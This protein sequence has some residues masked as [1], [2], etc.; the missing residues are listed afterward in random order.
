[1]SRVKKTLRL[2][3]KF[4]AAC[5][6]IAVLGFVEQ[7]GNNVPVR[8][9]RVNLA[10]AGDV[11]F[12]DAEA[13]KLQV[14]TGTGPV[15]G[16]PVNKLDETAIEQHLRAIPCVAEADV[17]HTMDGVLHV[18]ARQREP[19]VRVVNADGTGFYIDKEGWTMPLDPNYTARVMVVTGMLQEPFGMQAPVNVTS[20][21][22]SLA[23]HSH[24]A[25]IH[26]LA[27]TL[28]KNPFWSALFGQ[29]VVDAQGEFTLV[30]NVGMMQVRVGDGSHLAQRLDKLKLFY[31]QGLP[32]A[33]WRRYST[34]D[35]RFDDQV[36][37]T[38]RSPQ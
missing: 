15:I 6:V 22:D 9:V 19:I 24:C 4:A 26:A 34:V 12:I 3:A 8:E 11:H 18:N 36:V 21:N 13:L 30:P 10:P 16:T 29:A 7:R 14:A 37:A 35:L 27:T 31:Q 32:Q 1:M 23:M 28:R 17:Y 38:K 33:D 25:A 5:A 20:G 2:A